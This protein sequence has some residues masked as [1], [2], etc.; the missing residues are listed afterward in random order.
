MKY[1]QVNDDKYELGV[2]GEKAKAQ[3]Q[4]I[5]ELFERRQQLRTIAVPTDDIK[6]KLKLRSL[7]HP[8]TLFGERVRTICKDVFIDNNNFE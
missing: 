4:A 6:V 1:L 7:S 2:G 3:H 5:E 8:I